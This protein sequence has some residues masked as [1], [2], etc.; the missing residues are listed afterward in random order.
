MEQEYSLRWNNYE[1]HLCLVLGSMFKKGILVDVTLFAEGTAHKVH[2][3]VLSA[4]SPYFEDIF[5]AT[6]NSHPVIVLKDV[7]SEEL[8]A[9]IDY[10]YT[11]QVTV[12]RS[13]LPGFLKVAE[14]LK[15]RGLANSLQYQ[16]T[17][18]CDNKCTPSSNRKRKMSIENEDE[19]LLKN[20]FND[21]NFPTDL[22]IPKAEFQHVTAIGDTIPA[23]SN[24][25][26]VPKVNV[27]PREFLMS[28]P[29]EDSEF[30]VDRGKNKDPVTWCF[31]SFH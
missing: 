31:P 15:I 29:S 6:S 14:G 4:C 9:L 3:T 2:R 20:N 8:T 11:G 17:L 27:K 13:K 5:A 25:G 24:V 10:M 28:S 18:Y 16:E 21:Q 7:T 26:E 23:P 1:S 12:S 19:D 30:S 22:S